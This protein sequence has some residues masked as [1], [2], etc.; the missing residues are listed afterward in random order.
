VAALDNPAAASGAGGVAS[1]GYRWY[2]GSQ[3][4]SILGTMMS[5]TALF[6]LA[7][8]I[9]PGG[10]PVL[11]AVDAAQCL[12]MLLFSR[13]AG[14]IVARH[15]A[16]RI[17]MTT[18]G[19]QA[20]GAL[21]IGFPLLAGWMSIWYLI[22]LCFV[23]G[24]IQCV[25]LPARQSFMLDLVGPGELRRGSS[26]FATVTG[27]AKITGP[28]VAGIIIAA[29]G[30]TAVFFLD[31]AS[32]LGVIAVLARL[33]GRVKPA[34]APCREAIAA[35]RLRWL[36]DLPRGVQAAAAMAL[37]VGG[38]GLQF[39]VTN[40]LMA[41]RVFHLG[42]V[43]FGLFGTFMAVGGIAGNY[44]SA[45]RQDPG[46]LEFMAWSGVFGVAECLAA[47]MPVAWA[48][49]GILVALG[50]ATQLFAVSA[51]VYVQQATPAAQRGPALSAYNAGFIGF[52]PAGA[53][54]VAA[55]AATA[56]TRWALIGP[57]LAIV[58]GAVALAGRERPVSRAR[59]R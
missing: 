47:V 19:L 30:E 11:A 48:Y 34:E 9:R 36:L 50:A 52:V 7:L 18:Q 17:A 12:P 51:T 57:G 20:A 5:Y 8:H 35:R 16:A 3:V 44:Y 33:S 29:S 41:S 56:G 40:P 21:A 22:P 58:A 4:L 28:G 23:I 53:F 24:C 32:F 39:A 10:A 26:L 25:D 2:L 49:D 45:H 37:L 42:S 59:R 54:V 13:R 1:A 31:A 46:P 27:L 38:F 43:G 14:I 6:W 15:R 55:I